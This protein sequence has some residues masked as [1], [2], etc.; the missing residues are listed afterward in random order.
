M[1]QIP[2]YDKLVELARSCWRESQL[3]KD[4]EVARV[5]SDMAREF[6]EAAAKLNG[7]KLPESDE[8]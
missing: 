6:Q 7:G 1:S 3:T 8:G 5:L 4:R 2:T